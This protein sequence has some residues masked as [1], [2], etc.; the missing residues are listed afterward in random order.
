MKGKL[1]LCAA[2]GA[3]MMLTGCVDGKLVGMKG[4]ARRVC[5]EQ[6]LQPGTPE[7]SSCWKGIAA[8]DN[9]E[10]GQFLLGVAAGAVAAQAPAP[11]RPVIVD[12]GKIL[13]TPPPKQCV[14]Y[15]KM[16]KR[17]VQ[18]VNGVCPLNYGE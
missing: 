17:V 8:A 3:T 13:R 2:A 16:G 15:T 1:L 14:Y 12:H 18:A 5:Y 9:A 4:S 10:V 11:S 7:H 6:G